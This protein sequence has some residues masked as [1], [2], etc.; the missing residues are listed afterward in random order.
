MT[1]VKYT[2]PIA[3]KIAAAAQYLGKEDARHETWLEVAQAVE[4]TTSIW[5]ESAERDGLTD[6]QLHGMAMTY[7]MER[8]VADAM[9]IEDK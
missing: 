6:D 8:L 4:D 2:N 7:V 1:Y 5:R 9:G 3:S